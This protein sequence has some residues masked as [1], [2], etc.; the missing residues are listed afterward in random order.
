MQPYLRRAPLD[1]G[2][3]GTSEVEKIEKKGG[4]NS[5]NREQTTPKGTKVEP[6]LTWAADMK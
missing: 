5:W 2:L 4:W 6:G 3:R 1:G